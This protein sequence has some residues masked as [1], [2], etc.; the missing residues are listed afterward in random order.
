MRRLGVNAGL[1]SLFE[2][3]GFECKVALIEVPSQPREEAAK[4]TREFERQCGAAA[5]VSLFDRVPRKQCHSRTASHPCEGPVVV[6]QFNHFPP[7]RQQFWLPDCCAASDSEW[8]VP[9]PADPGDGRGPV[10]PVLNVTH[11]S[12]HAVGGSFDFDIGGEIQ[13]EYEVTLSLR[14]W[15]W[16]RNRL[17]CNGRE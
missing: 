8:T 6:F 13:H 7:G 5:I 3:L 1:T 11:N 10:R 16:M 9:Y 4:R 14:R 2:A 15:R 12:P 17:C